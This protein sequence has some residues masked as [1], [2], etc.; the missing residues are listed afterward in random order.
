VTVQTFILSFSFA[1]AQS[2]A[3]SVSRCTAARKTLKIGSW[4]AIEQPVKEEVTDGRFVGPA[5]LIR[6]KPTKILNY[7]HPRRAVKHA[8][9]PEF[10]LPADR[11]PMEYVT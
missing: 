10:T 2:I 7:L 4:P 5:K 8:F 11:L 1:F 3:K 9:E 6:T